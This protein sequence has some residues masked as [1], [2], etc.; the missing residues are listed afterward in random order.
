M[1]ACFDNKEVVYRPLKHIKLNLPLWCYLCVCRLCGL[2][3]W[4]LKCTC[5]YDMSKVLTYTINN[6]LSNSVDVERVQFVVSFS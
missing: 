3:A 2:N 6:L 4:V 1:A 5:E